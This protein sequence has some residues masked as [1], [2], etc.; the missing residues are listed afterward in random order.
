MG[1]NEDVQW[2]CSV[3][4]RAGAFL[5]ESQYQELMFHPYVKLFQ[6]VY[7]ES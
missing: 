5:I 6:G 4:E 7:V 1:V 2:H 3:L